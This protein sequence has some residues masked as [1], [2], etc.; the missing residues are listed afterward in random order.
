MSK[1]SNQTFD[2]TISEDDLHYEIKYPLQ[3]TQGEC[4][5]TA[6]RIEIEVEEYHNLGEKDKGNAFK[7][8]TKILERVAATLIVTFKERELTTDFVVNP[9]NLFCQRTIFNMSLPSQ[10]KQWMKSMVCKPEGHY[11]GFRQFFNIDY[12]KEHSPFLLNIVLSKDVHCR[13]CSK[14]DLKAKEMQL[15]DETHNKIISTQ[16]TFDLFK[17]QNGIKE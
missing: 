4:H 12:L 14:E 16:E 2:A 11:G 3:F 17:K 15:Y 1:S 9:G 13:Q 7:R 5:F 10:P 6:R 8:N